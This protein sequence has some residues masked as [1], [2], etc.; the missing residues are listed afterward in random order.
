METFSDPIKEYVY[1][2]FADYY[3]N[4]VL[5]KIKDDGNFSLY[6]AKLQCLLLNEDRYIIALIPRDNYPYMRQQN[7]GQLRW[8]CLQIR[9]LEE[10]YQLPKQAYSQKRSNDY[11][12]RIIL[13]S[14]DNDITTYEVEELPVKISLMHK[15][16]Q[17]YEFP[18]RGTLVSALETFRTIVHF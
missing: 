10:G 11:Q 15:L 18:D 7:I 1:K 6:A 4:M 8:K 5:Y 3:D 13:Q 14:R 16:G 2:L 17:K 9:N 12:R